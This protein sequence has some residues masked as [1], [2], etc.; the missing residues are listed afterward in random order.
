MQKTSGYDSLT[1]TQTK[2]HS[3]LGHNQFADSNLPL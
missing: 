3:Q 2:I 1:M